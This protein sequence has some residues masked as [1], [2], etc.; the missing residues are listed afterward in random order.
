MPRK[1]SPFRDGSADAPPSLACLESYLP[2][3]DCRDTRGPSPDFARTASGKGRRRS[4]Q[5]D[6]VG[7]LRQDG[8][9]ARA[10]VGE[11]AGDAS[12]GRLVRNGVTGAVHNEDRSAGG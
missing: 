1:A 7:T 10:R 6:R 12:G 4:C 11:G 8:M 3:R 2:G 9:A 5:L